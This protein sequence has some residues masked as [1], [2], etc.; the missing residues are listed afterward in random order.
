MYASVM[1]LH[2]LFNKS[3]PETVALGPMR[4]IPLVEFIENMLHC[5]IGN[6]LTAV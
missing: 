1:Q 6:G 2:N 4:G 5:F 3:K